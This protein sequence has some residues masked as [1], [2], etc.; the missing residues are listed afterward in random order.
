MKIKNKNWAPY[1]Q[2]NTCK[3]YIQPTKQIF[4]TGRGKK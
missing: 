3:K 4:L 2:Q 1:Q